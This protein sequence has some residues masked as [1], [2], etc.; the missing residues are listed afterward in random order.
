MVV[1]CLSLV[2]AGCGGGGTPSGD[3]GDVSAGQKQLYQDAVAEGGKV[4]VFLGTPSHEDTDRLIELFNEAF[5]D[6]EVEYVG[7]TGDEVTERLL[8]EKRSG[9][10]NADVL[11]LAG[12]SAFERVADEGFMEEF[13]PEDAALFTHD[14]ADHI[15]GVAY[16]FGSIYNAVCFNPDNV[17]EEEAKLLENYEGWTDPRWKGRASIINPD[18]F[19]LRFGLTHWVY[20]DPD[21]GKDWLEDLAALDP[22]VYS[23]G[24]DAPP[25]VIA[26]DHDVMFNALSIYGARAYRDGAPLECK[27]GEYAPYYTFAAGLVKDAPNSAAGQL[28]INWL[29]SEA[30]QLAV[31]ETYAFA[32][33]RDGMD[34]PVVDADWWEIPEDARLTDETIVGTNYE[35]LAETF[36]NLFGKSTG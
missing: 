6:I 18:G 26:G 9:L 28:F 36:N 23:R 21:L 5:P 16:S 20:Q 10:N 1:T 14:N 15:D 34:T 24:T 3:V 32:A 35:D 17:S 19:G 8:T 13:T 29:F 31:Q 33:R 2:V 22:T 25:R 7:S 11:M 4:S 12:L 30:G 27:T